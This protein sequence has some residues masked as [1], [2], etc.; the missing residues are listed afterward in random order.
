L[1]G[2]REA[3]CAD[4]KKRHAELEAISTPGFELYAELEAISTPGF[5]LHAELEAIDPMESLGA[6]RG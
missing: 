4:E 1:G 5:E 6:V 3:R 2:R